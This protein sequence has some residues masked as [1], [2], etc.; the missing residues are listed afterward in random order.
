M[1][2][3]FLSRMLG[4]DRPSVTERAISLQAGGAIEYAR[5]SLRILDRKKLE[6]NSCECYRALRQFNRELGLA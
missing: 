2:H 5:G 6:A 4:R 1:T 3:D